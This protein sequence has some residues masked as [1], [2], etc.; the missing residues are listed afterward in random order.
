MS[1][2][3]N[4]VG[5]D[6]HKDSV[7]V[8]ILEGDEP[9]DNAEILTVQHTSKAVRRLVK[10]LSAGDTEVRACY[11]A[12]P[13]GYGLHRFLTS[14]GIVCEVIA[15][16]LIPKKPGD[17]V[18]TDR[19][20]AKKLASLYRSGLLTPIAVPGEDQEALRDL[21]R[22]RQSVVKQVRAARHQLGK[23]LL[24]RERI[25]R[26]TR[27]WTNKHR[28]WIAR[29]EF[30][31]VA[32]RKTFEHYRTHLEYLEERLSELEA[33]IE[34]I[35]EDEPYREV[36]GRLS[37]LRGIKTLTAMTLV[38]E[39]Y[40]F[41]R[42]PTADRFAAYLGLVTSEHSTGGPGREK[43][44]SITKTGNMHARKILVEAAWHARHK[45]TLNNKALKERVEGQPP[46]IVRHAWKA[47]R[48]LH[49]VYW[50]LVSKGKPTPVA[51]VAVAREL[52]GFVWA[53]MTDEDLLEGGTA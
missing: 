2:S 3:I 45:P 24:R 38:A 49:K 50:R 22:A 12:G 23:F 5:L 32:T 28:A 19:R 1:E 41:R 6:V 21:L 8:A 11:E 53:L 25:F 9:Q 18:K 13:C 46:G 30:D 44:G 39:I 37:C 10:R 51:V 36:V 43:R 34:S 47:Q 20:D 15:P 33:E 26:E 14:L 4:W 40:D 17:R 16:S 48:R 42:F 29:Q 7:V 31:H 27:N 35:A 52:A